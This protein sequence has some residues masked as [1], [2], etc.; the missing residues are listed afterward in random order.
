[1]KTHDILSVIR[2]RAPHESGVNLKISKVM[3]RD[4]NFVVDASVKALAE[5]VAVSEPSIIRYCR[6]IGCEGFKDFK[7]QLAQSLILDAK[8]SLSEDVGAEKEPAVGDRRLTRASASVI[9]AIAS[10]SSSGHFLRIDEAAKAIVS[11]HSI[12]V[13]GVGGSSG[14]LAQEAQNR[15]FRLGLQ[16]VAYSDG[17]MQR[18]SASTMRKG[19]VIV[20]IS[21]TGQ[22]ESLKDSC[23]IAQSSGATAICI[24]PK[25]SPIAS[26]ADILVPVELEVDV[27]FQRPNPVRYAQLFV[28]DCIAERAALLLGKSATDS[29]RRVASA[30][31]PLKPHQPVGD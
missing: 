30:I 6:D 11:S 16:V 12:V 20:V 13:M 17:Y 23:D 15:F 21:A 2:E 25:A 31:A 4:L 19:D 28:L 18:M 10:V 24:A 26:V 29:L 9:S 22:P 27:P 8:F 1:V 14:V 7:K 5:A 3:L